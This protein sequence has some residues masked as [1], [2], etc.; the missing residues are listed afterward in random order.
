V[1]VA[2]CLCMSHL[3]A[4]LLAC[5]HASPPAAAHPPACLFC[6][7]PFCVQLCGLCMLQLALGLK[8]ERQLGFSS[9]NSPVQR[10]VFLTVDRVFSI[11]FQRQGLPEARLKLRCGSSA[12]QHSVFS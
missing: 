6:C 1:F 7:P 8:L 5:P 10:H 9:S 12:H 3:L 2:F 11:T 4:C